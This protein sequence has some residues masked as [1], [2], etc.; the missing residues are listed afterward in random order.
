M[1]RYHID[2]LLGYHVTLSL[3]VAILEKFGT[4]IINFLVK[5]KHIPIDLIGYLVY[6][7]FNCLTWQRLR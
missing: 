6:N 1:M 3:L 4:G 2:V 7:M 5:S